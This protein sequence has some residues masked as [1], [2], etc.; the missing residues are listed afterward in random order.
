MSPVRMARIESAVR[1]V[2]EFS[3]A[4]NRHDVAGMMRLVSDDCVF[5]SAEPA[6]D[7]AVYS[8]K[9]A[10]TQFWQDFFR[11][12]PHA[13]IEIEKV[14]GFGI[15]CIARWRYDW[16]DAA[17]EKRHMRGLDVFRVQNGLIYE[18]LSYVKGSRGE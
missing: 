8:G 12:S 16:V 7:G 13:R 10:I 14:S 3:E 17:G 6:P 15:W 4:F 1:A 5:E 18:Q 11:R 2:L 9:E